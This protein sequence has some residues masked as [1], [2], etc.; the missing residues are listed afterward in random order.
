MVDL[1]KR[2]HGTCLY[3]VLRVLYVCVLVSATYGEDLFDEIVF[4]AGVSRVRH[5]HYK[6]LPL[7]TTAGI[8]LP[9]RMAGCSN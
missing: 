1:H 5:P 8:V 9:S 7:L 4:L 6:Y 3:G 2:S